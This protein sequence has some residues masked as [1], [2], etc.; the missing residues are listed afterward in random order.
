MK[1]KRLICIQTNMNTKVYLDINISD[2]KQDKPEIDLQVGITGRNNWKKR[3]L[4][5]MSRKKSLGWCQVVN[6]KKTI[7]FQN[8]RL[9]FI[10][11]VSISYIF[12]LCLECILLVP[13]FHFETSFGK[14]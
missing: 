7:C 3:E 12:R 10:C 2:W 8:L 6:K 1:H 14:F 11:S 9:V 4:S 5:L 13:S